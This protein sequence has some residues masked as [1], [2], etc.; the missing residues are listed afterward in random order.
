MSGHFF[1]TKSLGF[2]TAVGMVLSAGLSH[3][4]N[5]LEPLVVTASRTE[6]GLSDLPYSVSGLSAAEIEDR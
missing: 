6:T 3:A 4:Q 1:F 5:V 2:S